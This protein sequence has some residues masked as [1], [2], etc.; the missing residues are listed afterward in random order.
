MPSASQSES[1]RANLTQIAFNPDNS[2]FVTASGS[3][4]RFD[5]FSLSNLAVDGITYP[6]QPYPN[7]RRDHLGAPAA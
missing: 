3:P 6:A 5:E 4:Y 1:D 2:T 7:S